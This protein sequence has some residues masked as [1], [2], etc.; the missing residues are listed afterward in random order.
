MLHIACGVWHTAAVAAQPLGM[1][2]AGQLGSADMDPAEWEAIQQK[3]ADAYRMLDEV[4][5]YFIY[6]AKALL[7][8]HTS[9]AFQPL[10]WLLLKGW[11]SPA[12]PSSRLMRF[13]TAEN[14]S[15]ESCHVIL[16]GGWPA[17]YMGRSI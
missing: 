6:H 17:V 14:R 8:S 3:M 10:A 12:V 5:C 11:F 2:A 9:G 15:S 16:A 13:G 4:S 7:E 1:P